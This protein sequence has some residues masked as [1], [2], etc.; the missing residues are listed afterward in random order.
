[1]SETHYGMDARML[2]A[3]MER[4]AVARR[5]ARPRLEPPP[6]PTRTI[7]SALRRRGASTP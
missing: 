3:E 1:M 7:R 6:A 5:A 4:S 2:E